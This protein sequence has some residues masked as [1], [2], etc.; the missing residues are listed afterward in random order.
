MELR[1]VTYKDILYICTASFGLASFFFASRRLSSCAVAPLGGII[2]INPSSTASW[3]VILVSLQVVSLL[4]LA[5]KPVRSVA[6]LAE[7]MMTRRKTDC[8]NRTV[9]R[10]LA[11]RVFRGERRGGYLSRAQTRRRVLE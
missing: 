7:V 4:L 8:T 5:S 2:V 11:D 1:E 3:R 9:I 6:L 10:V